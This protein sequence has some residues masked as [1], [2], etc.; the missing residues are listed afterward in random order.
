MPLPR[1]GAPSPGQPLQVG[2]TEVGRLRF[3][4][5]SSSLEVSS[6][7]A[8]AAKLTISIAKNR[9]INIILS[10]VLPHNIY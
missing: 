5:F 8:V 7:K 2:A 10:L 1:S 4:L 9:R 6:A 3:L